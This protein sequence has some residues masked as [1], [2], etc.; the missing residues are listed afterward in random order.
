MS[1]K[2]D[3]KKTKEQSKGFTLAELLVAMAIF[4][5][6]ILIAG[7]IFVQS[8]RSGRIITGRA[9]AFD[10]VALTIE[11]IAREV[12]T[13]VDFPEAKRVGSGGGK[14][15]QLEFTNYHNKEV[16]YRLETNSGAVQK[17]VNA[18]NFISITSSSVKITRLNFHIMGD[19]DGLP[20]RITIFIEAEGP[21]EAPLNLQ[22]T[23]GA[24]LIYYKPIEL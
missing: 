20:P 5:L 2:K 15:N 14:F 21:F 24:R 7:A 19:S 18:G 8:I 17:S 22:T 10:N 16:V 11:Q 3:F 13:G 1:Q 6:I 23:V 9:A 12:R 4:S